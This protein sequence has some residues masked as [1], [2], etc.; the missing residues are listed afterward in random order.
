MF[1]HVV[2][3]HKG[4]W[5]RCHYKHVSS[6]TIR[7]FNRSHMT[8]QKLKQ[9]QRKNKQKQQ[10]QT[11]KCRL[12]KRRNIPFPSVSFKP[13]TMAWRHS[14]TIP[15]QSFEIKNVLFCILVYLS[16]DLL[17]RFYKVQFDW[18]SSWKGILRSGNLWEWGQR[19][20]EKALVGGGGGS[21]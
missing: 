3:E 5:C 9:K 14:Q 1:I 21:R 4:K 12:S 10:Q 13:I 6:L 7:L 19:L 15:S 16:H 18:L 20:P 8:S 2:D 11:I 17:S